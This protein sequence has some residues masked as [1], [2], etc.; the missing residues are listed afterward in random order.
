MVNMF[1]PIFLLIFVIM[2]L[3]TMC[4]TPDVH[5]EYG[6]YE[7]SSYDEMTLQNYAD[8]QYAK[9][10]SDSA[11]Y[12]D[13]LLIV[14]LTAEDCYDYYYIAW[15]GDHIDMNINYMMGDNDTELG[16]A[17]SENINASNYKYSLDSN[18]AAVVNSMAKQIQNL[19]LENSL[20]CG[21]NHVAVTAQLVNNTELPMTQ[22]TVDDALENF[23]DVTGIPVVVVVEDMEDVFGS[24]ALSTNSS[25]S[26]LSILPV[27]VIVAI[28][29]VVIF[30]LVRRKKDNDETD[31]QDKNKQYSQFD[32]YYK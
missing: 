8:E 31:T 7:S 13:N 14:F 22:S 9:Y 27:L 26:V 17:M 1:A 10:F 4:G 11:C 18:L 15:V 32:D 6:D 20:S 29:I 23:A 19:G 21:T 3:L 16:R 30:V 5:V 24:N 2:F 28:V 25:G 12:E